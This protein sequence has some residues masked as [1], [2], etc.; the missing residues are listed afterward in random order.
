MLKMSSTCINAHMDMS[1]DGLSHLFKGPGMIV[2]GF[3]MHQKYIR[4]VSIHFQLLL[5][6][7]TIKF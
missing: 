5:N 2:N 1:R 6:T 3:D 4:A 7:R